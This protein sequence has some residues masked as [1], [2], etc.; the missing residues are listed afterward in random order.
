M[1]L[2]E[3]SASGLS[4]LEVVHGSEEGVISEGGVALSGG[5]DGEGGDNGDLG[6]HDVRLG[7]LKLIISLGKQLQVNENNPIKHEK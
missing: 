7:L 2:D 6:E 4:F 1:L 3:G 5:D